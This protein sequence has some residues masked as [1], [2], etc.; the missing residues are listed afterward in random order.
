M[1]TYTVR[2][3]C[4]KK[5]RYHRYVEKLLIIDDSFTTEFRYDAIRQASKPAE[6]N[7]PATIHR[8]S[9][10]EQLKKCKA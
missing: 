1:K 10:R 4:D 2:I 3:F 7:D 8:N 5:L 6:E 9:A